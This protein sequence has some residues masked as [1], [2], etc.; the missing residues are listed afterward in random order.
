MEIVGIIEGIKYKKVINKELKKFNINDNFNINIASG[1]FIINVNDNNFAVSKWVSPKR[2]RSYPYERVYDTFDFKNKIAVIPVI[3]DEGLDGDRDFLQWDTICLMNLLDIYII[4]A[5]Y[6]N[7]EKNNSYDNKITNQC[8]DNDFIIAKIKEIS[9]YHSSALHW[10]TQELNNIN[11][12]IEKIKNSYNKIQNNIGVKLKSHSGIQ[13]YLDKINISLD[14]FK[15]F[16]RTKAIMAQN[17]EMQ[18]LQPKEKLENLTKSKITIQ[19]FQGGLYY[20][21]VD[22]IEYD[23]KTNTF[24]LIES[25][26]S[27]GG[28]LPISD[29]KDGLIKMI[30]YT[31]I[32]KIYLN[33][34]IYNF[35]P[36]LKIFTNCQIE[37]DNFIKDLYLEAE[38]N[39]FIIDL[40]KYD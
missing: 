13:A 14:T 27:K 16:S 26:C 19:N 21:T 33:N 38:C 39:N 29:I 1:S 37:D 30:L 28:G 22:E 35:R 7:A 6:D 3:K 15:K 8:F 12:V 9:L 32:T 20:F 18:T 5:Y 31:N 11:Y 36:V 40:K 25:K 10:N 24:F 34:R 17:R 4:F 23:Q 2:T